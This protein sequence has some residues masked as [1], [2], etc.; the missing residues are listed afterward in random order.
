ML[1]LI[2][3]Y[4]PTALLQLLVF[5]LYSPLY[6]LPASDPLSLSLLSRCR[7]KPLRQ[8]RHRQRCYTYL[9]PLYT[10]LTVKFK[11]ARAHVLSPLNAHTHAD[12]KIAGLLN[13]PALCFSCLAARCGRCPCVCVAVVAHAG[14]HSD[15]LLTEEE[16]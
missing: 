16:K 1:S 2:P 14:L 9:L 4:P 8:L 15:T 11:P 12:T 5:L 7:E 10:S 6:T 13:Q 3:G